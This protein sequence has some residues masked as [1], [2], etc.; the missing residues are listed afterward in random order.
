VAFVVRIIA[1]IVR[2]VQKSNMRFL[3]ILFLCLF[4]EATQAGSLKDTVQ[5]KE[6]VAFPVARNA[7]Q[8]QTEHNQSNSVDKLLL[9]SNSVYIKNYGAKALS[10]ITYRGTSAAQNDFYWNGVKINS[11]LTGQVD[12]SLIPIDPSQQFSISSASNAIGA[13]VSMDDKSPFYIQAPVQFE[14]QTRYLSLNAFDISNTLFLR[15]KGFYA[16]GNLFYHQGKYDF[17]VPE[18]QHGK[19][20]RKQQNSKTTQ[21]SARAAFG[22]SSKEHDVLFAM[23]WVNTNRQ[24]PPVFTKLLSQESQYDQSLR[25]MGRYSFQRKN[26]RL[27]LSA[28]CLKEE[29]RYRNPEINLISNNNSLVSRN[30]LYYRRGFKQNMFE[31]ELGFKYDFELGKSLNLLQNRVRNFYELKEQFFYSSRNRKVTVHATLYQMFF[32]KKVFVSGIAKS[33]I[34]FIKPSANLF[35]MQL[36]FARTL[37]FPSL[38]DLFWAGVGNP[39]LN[40]EK[41][42]KGDIHL[43]KQMTQYANLKV[44]AYGQYVQDWILWHPVTAAYWQPENLKKVYGYG[45][46]IEAVVGKRKTNDQTWFVYALGNYSWNKMTNLESSSVNDLSKGKQLIYVPQH[47]L[48]S[49]LVAGYKGFQTTFDVSYTGKV[50]IT[51]DNT[52]ALPAFMLMDIHVTKAFFIQRQAITLGFAVCNVANTFYQTIPYRAMPGRYFECS[53]KLNLKG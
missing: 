47:R 4:M 29:M 11:P 8:F 49:S 16:N 52:E 21:I 27:G 30:E 17:L 28:S 10:S 23:W 13:R 19:G 20:Y 39:N 1:V 34:T 9:N 36:S 31:A 48:N 7:K 43:E 42:W 25:I 15:H 44:G 37:R 5:L 3:F 38:N 41:G 18:G 22:Y 32:Q 51:T 2:I 45:V 35:V 53:V 24:L 50:Y 26:N 40:P 33:K 6:V 46:E 12:C 14:L